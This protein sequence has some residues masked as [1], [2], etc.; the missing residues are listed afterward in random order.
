MKLHEIS[1]AWLML[2]NQIDEAGGELSPELEQQFDRLE[3]NQADKV[4]RCCAL[5]R[6]R[7]ADAAMVE[8]EA[9]QHEAEAKRLKARAASMH[10][11]ADGIEFL[12]LQ[13]LQRTQQ[14]SIKTPFNTAF[15]RSIPAALA[16]DPAVSDE[17]VAEAFRCVKEVVK[18]DGK[19][20]ASHW[21]ETG[22]VPTGWTV[23]PSYKTLGLK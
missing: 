18:A 23:R 16:R 19:A 8:A 11:S 2:A 22:E 5:I 9:A 1:N 14:Q 12:L 10:G 20:A 4:D 15:Q 7:H 3:G 13:F 6:Q 17:Q 21:K